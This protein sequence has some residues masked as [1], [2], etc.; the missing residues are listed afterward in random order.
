[1]DSH[2][3]RDEMTPLLVALLVSLSLGSCDGVSTPDDEWV[4]AHT[5]R[6][7]P[8]QW[9]RGIA[10]PDGPFVPPPNGPYNSYGASIF[11]SSCP[12]LCDSR[13]KHHL[14]AAPPVTPK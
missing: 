14:F 5:V 6:G 10:A 7:M 9:V 2:R 3:S 11:W 1:M 8:A 12:E 4:Q 13:L